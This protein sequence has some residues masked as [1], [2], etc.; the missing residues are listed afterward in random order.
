VCV[1][2]ASLSLSLSLSPLLTVFTYRISLFYFNFEF[3]RGLK[4]GVRDDILRSM[5]NRKKHRCTDA[6]AWATS[7]YTVHP[8]PASLS[9]ILLVRRRD[10]DGGSS[11]HLMLFIGANA[12]A[13]AS[14][15]RGTSQFPNSPIIIGITMKKII[16]KAWAI[17]VTL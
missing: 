2:A 11:Q 4:L 7:C 12:L 1:C 9:T 13:G 3:K 5:Y 16:M 14:S 6:P 17:T 8:V 10:R 15:M